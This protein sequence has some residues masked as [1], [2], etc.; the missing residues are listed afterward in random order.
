MRTNDQDPGRCHCPECRACG[1]AGRARGHT[2]NLIGLALSNLKRRPIPSSLSS[3]RSALAVGS[4]LPLISLS[5]SSKDSTR[6]GMDEMGDDL[7]VMQKGASDIF[8]GF[9]PEP[10]VGRI[11][12]IPVL[13]GVSGELMMFAPS[14]PDKSII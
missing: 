14:G 10:T 2:M 8:G 3:L 7:I 12:A 9:I 6:D 1:V 13:V 4:P 11:A 5:C